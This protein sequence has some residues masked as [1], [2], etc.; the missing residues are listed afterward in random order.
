MLPLLV[1]LSD[2]ATGVLAL[3]AA[4]ILAP[5]LA[6]DLVLPVA[7]GTLAAGV[8]ASWV[9]PRLGGRDEPLLAY[10]RLEVGLALAA[11]AVPPLASTN[12]VAALVS[13]VPS[14]LLLGAAAPAL[15]TEWRDRLGHPSEAVGE[16][17][18]TRAAGAALGALVGGF[19]LLPVSGAAL[20]LR[21]GALIHLLVGVLALLDARREDLDDLDPEPFLPAEDE[22]PPEPP[23]PTPVAALG[24]AVVGA[25]GG[26]WVTLWVRDLG[27][28]LDASAFGP[29]VVL[30]MAAVG[31]AA[32]CS[33]AARDEPRRRNLGVALVLGLLG[34]AWYS[35]LRDV[36]PGL[37]HDAV[38]SQGLDFELASALRGLLVLAQV[39]PIAAALGLARVTLGALRDE[40]EALDAPG[41]PPLASAAALAMVGASFV[42]PPPGGPADHDPQPLRLQG[43]VAWTPGA[44]PPDRST[45]GLLAAALHPQPRRALVLGPAFA[46]GVVHPLGLAGADVHRVGGF[47][48]ELGSFE[49]TLFAQAPRTFLTRRGDPYDVIVTRVETLWRPEDA[50]LLTLEHLRRVQGRLRAEGLAVLVFPRRGVD[51]PNASRVVHT[52]REVFP[53]ASLWA[54]CR[55]ELALVARAEGPAIPDPTRLAQVLSSPR[56]APLAQAQGWTRPAALSV[57]NLVGPQV[58]PQWGAPEVARCTEDD[59]VVLY[60]GARAE[61][62]GATLPDP[63]V[64]PDA[65]FGPRPDGEDPAVQ[66]EAG[67]LLVR[68]APVQRAL[69]LLG[70]SLRGRPDDP[71]VRFWMGSALYRR[72]QPASAAAIEY[73][74]DA[75]RQD[76]NAAVL[77][78]FVVEFARPVTLGPDPGEAL[79]R[80][81]DL[82]LELARRQQ[83]GQL[84]GYRDPPG[85]WGALFSELERMAA[86]R[87]RHADRVRFLD[88]A[89]RVTPAGTP[90]HAALQQARASLQVALQRLRADAAQLA[91]EGFSARAGEVRRR[92]QQLASALG[93]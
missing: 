22:D 5:H 41:L 87:G 64:A 6:G 38:R 35:G 62:A 91:Q 75:A 44:E 58:L 21:T 89:A 67:L 37:L 90:Q 7:F 32:G 76:G 83:A 92:A 34:I 46:R 63:E 48:G 43:R 82:G 56:L 11:F 36:V 14:G 80:L 4:A 24:L 10:G 53:G 47:V 39:L 30:A 28:T 31:V 68:R 59:P 20:T 57:L 3:A 33:R 1:L 52:F 86:F 17:A 18:S 66:R 77:A 29:P 78:T 19:L 16:L 9:L 40:R 12:F 49:A 81:V 42:V 27:A 65:L 71:E 61:F 93:S 88:A 25:F 73:L 85:G 70:A 84:E 79:G 55:G 26:A 45:V 69:Q 15:A 50:A 54:P 51:I 2:L 8:G 72:D 60:E 74:L 13:L 23:L